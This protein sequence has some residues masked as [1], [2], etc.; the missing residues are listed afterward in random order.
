MS[1]CVSA[2]STSKKFIHVYVSYMYATDCDITSDD[3]Q[4]SVRVEGGPV[5]SVEI[6]FRH[7]DQHKS[8]RNRHHLNAAARTDNVPRSGRHLGLFNVYMQ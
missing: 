1:V 7:G 3:R 5:P 8:T 6:R 4:M 2:S